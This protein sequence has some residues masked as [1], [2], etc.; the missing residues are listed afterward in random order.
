MHL[1]YTPFCRLDYDSATSSY[2]DAAGVEVRAPGF[3]DTNTVE[4]LD[5]EGGMLLDGSFAFFNYFVE[6]GYERGKTIRAAPYD[7]RLAPGN[8]M[9]VKSNDDTTL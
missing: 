6:R 9:H 3:G 8:T 5:T 1:L 7:W 4:Y 2:S